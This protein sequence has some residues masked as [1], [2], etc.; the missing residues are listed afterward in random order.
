VQLVGLFSLA[1]LAAAAA[2]PQAAGASIAIRAPAAS[3]P[4]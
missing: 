3:E 2:D 4:A 1:T